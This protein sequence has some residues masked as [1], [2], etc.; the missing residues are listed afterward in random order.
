MDNTHT[1]GTTYYI[2]CQCRGEAEPLTSD[3]QVMIFTTKRAA[4]Q[5]AAKM[6]ILME[7]GQKATYTVKAAR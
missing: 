5:E 1:H 2:L 4:S 3:G 7:G 6:R